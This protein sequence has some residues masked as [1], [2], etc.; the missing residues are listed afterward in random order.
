MTEELKDALIA[1]LV[2]KLETFQPGAGKELMDEMKYLNFITEHEYNTV[3][4]AIK[5][6]DGTRG[7][8]L[9]IESIKSV[10]NKTNGAWLCMEPY[11]NEWALYL[12]I[13]HL[14][15][16]NSKFIYEVSN[17]TGIPSVLIC[18]DLASGLLK[19]KNKSRW[20]RDHFDL[21]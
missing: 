21:D 3:T 9:S 2:N 16:T 1:S 17:K 4:Q 5:N 12:T 15:S 20:L 18:Y 11:Y 7:P 8:K 6:L 19:D 14:M 10:I 13:N